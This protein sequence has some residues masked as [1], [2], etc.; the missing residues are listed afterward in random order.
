MDCNGAQAGKETLALLIRPE[1]V[2]HPRRHVVDR[3]EGGGRSAA[4]GQFLEDHRGVGARQRRPADIVAH[5]DAA[6]PQFGRLAQRIHREMAV[7][8]PFPG[9]GLHVLGGKLRGDR[10]KGP[11]ILAEFEVH[12]RPFA[13]TPAEA[14]EISG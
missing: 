5:I 8:I 6:E 14:A 1:R 3:D 4:L 13:V 7:G 10:L 2:D 11:L 9:K 12:A